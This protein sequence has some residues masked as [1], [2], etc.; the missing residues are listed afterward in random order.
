[1]ILA[2]D[3]AT[4]SGWALGGPQDGC[5]K[6][7]TWDFPGFSVGCLNATLASLHASVTQFCIAAKVRIVA[8]EAPLLL[9][10][11]SPHTAIGLIS[12]VGVARCAAYQRGANVVLENV[13][14]VRRHFIGE[15]RPDNPKE[16]VLERC[17]LLGWP[18]VDDNAGDAAALWCWAM[19]VYHPNWAPCG[20]P[21]F[22]RA[23]A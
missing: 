8:I 10:K 17:E 14:T 6:T 11:R 7:G 4:R 20:T 1:V 9:P 19:S 5:P 22:R 13:Q 18:A 16:A 2:L 12:M 23:V 21:L 3:L 15:A